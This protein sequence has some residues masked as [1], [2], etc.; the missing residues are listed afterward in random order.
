[1]S[2]AYTLFVGDL[3]IYCT[4]EDIER[5]FSPF[6]TIKDIRIKKD[7]QTGKYLSYGFVEFEE[8]SAAVNALQNM[9]GYVLCGRPM[10]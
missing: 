7:E 2:S 5:A 4:K 9:N 10:R 3:S 1:M 6:G 8:V